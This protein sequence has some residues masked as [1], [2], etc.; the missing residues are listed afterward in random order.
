METPNT[1]ALS[2]RCRQ[3]GMRDQDIVR[4]FRTF[5]A[6]AEAFRSASIDADTVGDHSGR[7]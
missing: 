1:V 6:N 5:N 7:S 2:A 3:L 4:V